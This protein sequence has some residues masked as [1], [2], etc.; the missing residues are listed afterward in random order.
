[1]LGQ[2][3]LYFPPED[4]EYEVRHIS[5]VEFQAISS[6]WEHFAGGGINSVDAALIDESVK[7]PLAN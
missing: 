7:E 6:I 1:M 5:N 4:S 2:T 3:D